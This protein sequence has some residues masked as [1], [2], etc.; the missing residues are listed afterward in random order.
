MRYWFSLGR[1]RWFGARFHVHLSVVVV[2]ALV[3]LAGVESP[4]FAAVTLASFLGLIVLHEFGHAA[5]AHRFGY[6]VEGIWLAAV[7]GRCEFQAPETQ[8]QQCVIAWGGVAAQ[9]AV[10]IPLIAFDALWRRP[11]GILGPVVLILGYYSGIVVLLNLLPLKGL[12]GRR[13]WKIIPLLRKRMEAR[14]VVRRAL[15]RNRGR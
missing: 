2:S 9:L 15:G 12:D 10:A 3:A 7:H 6:S 8:W 5:V 1:S 13:A 4:V 14:K 11:L